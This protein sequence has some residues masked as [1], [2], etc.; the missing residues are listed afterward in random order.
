M[1]MKVV[2]EQRLLRIYIWI[3]FFVIKEIQM[4][5][6]VVSEQRLLRI[7]TGINLFLE[8]NYQKIN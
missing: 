4:K 5:M 3:Y 7:Y 2:S 8:I 6:K 1:K